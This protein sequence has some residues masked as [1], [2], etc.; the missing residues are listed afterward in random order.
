MYI[1]QYICEKMMMRG[2]TLQQMRTLGM[3]TQM[4]H[5]FLSATD[6]LNLFV[7]ILGCNL[8]SN[9]EMLSLHCHSCSFTSTNVFRSI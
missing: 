1:V 2:L 7:S 4:Y 5:R 6:H 9:H 8:G 3:C